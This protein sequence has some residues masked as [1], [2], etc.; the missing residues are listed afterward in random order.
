MSANVHQKRRRNETMSRK[1]QSTIVGVEWRQ[2]ENDLH[3]IE[4][5]RDHWLKV[6]VDTASDRETSDLALCA[7]E[8]MENKMHTLRMHA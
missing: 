4:V 7:A 1:G 5:K 2:I 6:A 8:E 3:E